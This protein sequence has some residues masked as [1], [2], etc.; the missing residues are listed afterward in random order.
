[1]PVRA[2]QLGFRDLYETFL[3]KLCRSRHGIG[4][5]LDP[6]NG[7]CISPAVGRRGGATKLDLDAALYQVC[8]KFLIWIASSNIAVGVIRL[9]VQSHVASICVKDRDHAGLGIPVGDIVHDKL[10]VKE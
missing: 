6:G 3:N 8:D 5:N 4:V 1:M 10:K 9:I 2:A 7:I